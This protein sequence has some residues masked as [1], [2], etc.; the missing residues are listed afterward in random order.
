MKITNPIIPGF[1]PDPTIA[2]FKDTYLLINSSFHVFPGL[3]IYSSRDLVN[4]EL[5]GHALSRPS[6][7]SLSNAFTKFIPLPH[8]IPLIITGG[9]FAPTL[10]HF[11]DRFYLVCT[12]A[13]EKPDGTHEFQ[14]FLLSCHEDAI[15]S[16]DGWSDAVPFEFPGIDPSLFFDEASGKAYLHGSYRTGPPWAP[17]C[18]IRQFEIN[19]DTGEALSECKFL[20]KGAAG[21]DDAEGPHIYFKDGWYYLLTAEASTF[22]GHQINIARSKDIWGPYESCPNNP[23]LTAFEKGEDVRWAGHGDL[24]QDVE[25]RWFCVHLGIRHNHSNVQRRPLGRETFLTPVEWPS[26]DWPRIAQTKLEMVV[27]S[28]GESGKA[29]GHGYKIL[30]EQ[31]EDL[32]IRTPNVDHYSYSATEDTYSLCAQTSTLTGALGT[33]TFVGR[34][35]RSLSGSASTTVELGSDKLPELPLAGL[36]IYK[37]SLRHGCI[38]IDG[39]NSTITAFLNVIKDKKSESIQLGSTAIPNGAAAIDLRIQTL[40]DGYE[41]LCYRQI[42]MPFS[43]PPLESR[44]RTAYIMSRISRGIC[45]AV[46]QAEIRPMPRSWKDAI[47]ELGDFTYPEFFDRHRG[48]IIDEY[49]RYYCQF[50]NRTPRSSRDVQYPIRRGGRGPRLFD[51]KE[52][53]EEFALMCVRNRIPLRSWDDIVAQFRG[54]GHDPRDLGYHKYYI[55]DCFLFHWSESVCKARVQLQIFMPNGSV[56]VHGTRGSVHVTAEMHSSRPSISKRYIERIG[57][58]QQVGEVVFLDFRVV[59]TN[60]MGNTQRMAFEVL[61]AEEA[62][63]MYVDGVSMT[64]NMDQWTIPRRNI[65]IGEIEIQELE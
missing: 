65:D 6:Q 8:G 7:L 19:V 13:F 50:H 16:D 43:R 22:E 56:S 59:D 46:M 41:F 26:G 37:D 58:N 5:K 12:Y 42:K 27:G 21:K 44:E 32:Y 63:D 33:S 10:R 20:W 23:L 38:Q 60:Y 11:K 15:F 51:Y 28:E 14:N 45:A 4:W 47:P 2:V 55:L 53:L 18:S 24:F 64:T 62:M 17:D 57:L 61:D 49:L 25:G 35:Q 3:P 48:K 40:P 39:P 1:A 30:N 36:T 34:R 54:A 29:Q 52:Q 9:L 31:L